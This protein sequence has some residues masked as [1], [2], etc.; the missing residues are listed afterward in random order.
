MAN[1]VYDI[2]TVTLQD[3]NDVEVRSLPLKLLRVANRIIG[4]LGK[5]LT[6]EEVS[7]GLTEEDLFY[8]RIASAAAVSISR[9]R[10]EV[11]D[12]GKQKATEAA[13]DLLD[14]PTIFRIIKI[15]TGVELNNPKL[16][17]IAQELT[18]E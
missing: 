16:V 9:Q 10:P 13:E 15:A 3:G 4:E 14:M 5:D 17:E 11:W 18:E 6:E 8:E 1:T 12:A 2:E 7:Q